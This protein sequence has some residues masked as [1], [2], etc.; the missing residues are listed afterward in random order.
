MSNMTLRFPWAA[1]ICVSGLLILAVLGRLLIG[2]STLGLPADSLILTARAELLVLG[3]VVGAS[4]AIS[5]VGLQVLLRNPLA[6]PYVLGLGSGAA[7]GVLLQGLL[8]YRWGLTL[9]PRMVAASLG[10]AAAMGIVLLAGRR[11]GLI[12]PVTLLLV[13]VVVSTV[14]GALLMLL[15]HLAGP[16]PIRDDL[17]RWMMGYLDPWA[18]PW[19]VFTLACLVLLATGWM[20]ASATRLDIAT[21]GSDEA[22]SLGVA[23]GR[24]RLE[25][26]LISAVLAGGAVALAGP[27]AFVGLIA[28]HLGRL[29]VGAGHFWLV[30]I[31]AILGAVLI[32]L[33][34]SLSSGIAYAGL[35]TGY[36]L[37]SL[38]IGIFTAMIGG[39]LFVILLRRSSGYPGESS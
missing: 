11:R 3:L 28:P 14:A 18:D 32:V 37:G 38:P 36:G 7:L 33:A 9:G 12:D 21:L 39:P 6:E 23:I 19:A 10:A 35:A 5:G 31:A 22:R 24:L 1:I 16:G 13:G 8:E 15:N 4:L 34:D 26:F 29:L 2:T 20:L 30:P 27:V 17:A 25:L